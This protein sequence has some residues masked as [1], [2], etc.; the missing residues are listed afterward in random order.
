MASVASEGS[1]PHGVA[2]SARG[3][4]LQAA[5]VVHLLEDERRDLHGIGP[6]GL[7]RGQRPPGKPGVEWLCAA[8]VP[9]NAL[10]LNGLGAAPPAPRPPPGPP[11]RPRPASPP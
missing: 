1:A 9:R 6:R 4:V 5:E 11:S 2:P 10:R 3:V 7:R 8:S